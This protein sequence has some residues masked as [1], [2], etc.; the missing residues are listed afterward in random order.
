MGK[1]FNSGK[2]GRALLDKLSGRLPRKK[3]GQA[4]S[5]PKPRLLVVGNGMVGHRFCSRLIAAGA[6]A[7]DITVLAEETV[8][9]YDRIHLNQIFTG[10]RVDDLLL[11]P[12]DWY[13][14]H[15]IELKLGR[16]VAR[17]DINEKSVDTLDGGEHPY[18]ILV[19][20]L[21]AEP[22]T[23]P[24][25]GLDGPGVLLYRNAADAQKI[26][27]A[28]EDADSAIVVGGGLLG[29]EVGDAIQELGCS[30]TIVEAA[31]FLMPRQLDPEGASG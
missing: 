23:P 27:S 3:I 1:V 21:G 9:A 16:A 8:P 15:G 28:A 11:S 22:K 6:E 30:T 10:T 2:P 5:G 14:E 24:V 29:L 7:F 20:A 4:R 12:R 19:L 17:I 31:D 26:R 25:P 18:D 13:G